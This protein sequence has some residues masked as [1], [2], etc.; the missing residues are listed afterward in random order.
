MLARVVWFHGWRPGNLCQ[1]PLLF[2]SP[3]KK[4]KKRVLTQLSNI[5]QQQQHKLLHNEEAATKGGT[6][7]GVKKRELRS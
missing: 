4:K 5:L 7:P 3:V 6:G 2:S 1:H